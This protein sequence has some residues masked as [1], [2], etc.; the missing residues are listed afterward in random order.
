MKSATGCFFLLIVASIA[1]CGARAAEVG[2]QF[3]IIW[4]LSVP[5]A[6]N[7]NTFH[8][9]G[10]KGAAFLFPNF[11]V[12]GYFFTADHAGELS[13]TQKFNY[14]LI[15]I[16]TAYHMPATSG[17]TFV[18]LRIGMTKLQ[19]N[20]TPS[21]DGTFSPYHYGIATGYDYL[22]GSMI[23]IGFEGSYLHVLPGR[24]NISG[25]DYNLD[26]FNL[27]NFLLTLQLRL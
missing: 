26:S 21:V 5:D 1:T 23:T 2:S 27:I 19:K 18:A 15:G 11:S 8:L 12:G 24:T 3:G 9:F 17:D 7:T 6:D 20:V 16:E 4:G 22:L 14:A 25:T 13:E 10:V